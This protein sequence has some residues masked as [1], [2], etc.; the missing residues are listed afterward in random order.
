MLTRTEPALTVLKARSAEREATP[1][2]L[3]DIRAQLGLDAGPLR[4]LGDWLGALPRGD[5]GR[6]WISG[7]EV[8]PGV[9]RALGASLLLMAVALTIA[10]LVAALVCARTLWSG[11]RRRG[12]GSGSAMVA[13]L[14][15][16]L[17]ASVLATVVGVQLGWLPALGWY[18]F[19]WTILPQPPSLE[20]GLLLA[21]N[22]PYAERAP[23]AVLAPAA[24]LAVLGALACTAAG[25][26]T[27]RPPKAVRA[28]RPLP[29][30]RELALP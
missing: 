19:Q 16:F 29:K 5:A 26:T 30:K 18:G 6:S 13:A 20:W 21:E 1:A 11:G 4:L 9:L 17:T 24:V 8:M 28:A 12:G 2:V 15:E 7:A 27:R 25:L 10:F 22:Q 14:P 23:W 3:A